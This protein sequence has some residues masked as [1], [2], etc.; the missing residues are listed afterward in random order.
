MIAFLNAD[1]GI[2]GGVILADIQHFI[3]GV[4]S[5]D[6]V[7]ASQNGMTAAVGAAGRV[8]V[9]SLSFV[10]LFHRNNPPSNK[11]Y[12][13]DAIPQHTLW[14]E[15]PQMPVVKQPSGNPV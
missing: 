9:D 13:K 14:G 6:T 3:P 11:K 12:R 10:F 4:L 1:I 8:W 7:C 5:I 2:A 15:S